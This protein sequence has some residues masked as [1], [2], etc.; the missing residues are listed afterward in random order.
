MNGSE[1]AQLVI[2]VLL[3]CL[4]AFFFGL[5]VSNWRSCRRRRRKHPLCLVADDG[6]DVPEIFLRQPPSTKGR[7]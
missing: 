7:I 2:L 4:S 3:L 1:I 5:F 6:N